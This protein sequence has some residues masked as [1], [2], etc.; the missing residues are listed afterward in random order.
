MVLS[1]RRHVWWTHRNDEVT[2]IEQ[3]GWSAKNRSA[4][5]ARCSL[6]KLLLYS[7]AGVYTRIENRPESLL[8]RP[9]S[10]RGSDVPL[11]PISRFPVSPR[12]PAPSL[13]C[14]TRRRRMRL[15]EIRKI[16]AHQPNIGRHPIAESRVR[17]QRENHVHHVVAEAAAV[18]G[19]KA[20]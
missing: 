14:G 18:E 19:G 4:N 3:S 6:H 9:T 8:T 2:R 20:E 12:V 15:A 5:P 16:W 7:C 11:S 17:D 13:L 1:D 10:L